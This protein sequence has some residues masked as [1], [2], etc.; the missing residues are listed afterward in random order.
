MT[1][2]DLSAVLW[3]ERE[4]L[5]LLLFKLETEQLLLAASRTRWLAHATGEVETVLREM[6]QVELSREVHSQ[7]VAQQLGLSPD[8]TLG[9]LAGR[10]PAPW[11]ELLAGHREAFLAIT[12]EVREVAETN[13]AQA[14]N[15]STEQNGRNAIAA[16]VGGIRQSLLGLANT[17]YL[18]RPIFAGSSTAT[19]AYD[20]SGTC[21]GDSRAL[22]RTIGAGNVVGVTV[23]GDQTFG[24]AGDDVFKQSSDL[25]TALRTDPTQLSGML[26]RLDA[27]MTRVQTQLSS[28][29]ST[30]N[31]IDTSRSTAGDTKLA[32]ASQL[33]SIQDLDLPKAAVALQMQQIAYQAALGATARVIQPT[34]MDYLK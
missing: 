31:R 34:L 30:Y 17:T 29:G 5:E 1:M 3:R 9:Q 23:T 8:A 14:I 12:A 20:S 15:A 33:S 24:P 6:G 2:S 32:M 16:E 18:N 28:V 25:S 13:R 27:T 19:Q 22:Q 26:D 4:L 7:E 21:Q 11:D 10:A